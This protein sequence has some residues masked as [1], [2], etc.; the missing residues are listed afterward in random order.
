VVRVVTRQGWLV[1]TVVGY[2]FAGAPLPAFART[3]EN[4]AP[5][6]PN[7]DVPAAM[8]VEVMSETSDAP[9][10]PEATAHGEEQREGETG[11]GNIGGAE[12]GETTLGATP[13]ESGADEEESS[14][15]TSTRPTSLS[16]PTKRSAT[17]QR[18]FGSFEGTYALGGVAVGTT[19]APGGLVLGGELSIVRQTQEFYWVG[20]YVDATYDFSR[21][22]TRVSVGPELGW[23]ALGLDAGY[24]LVLDGETACNGV[25][26]RPLVSIGYVTAYGRVSH[27]FDDRTWLEAGLLLKYPVEF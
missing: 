22:Q 8:E 20:G 13:S 14:A 4:A 2:L 27:L 21:K 12:A 7:P 1:H 17:D 6:L 16:L 9:T 11:E 18:M 5:E 3:Q 24:L 19:F 23:S 10:D 15:A 26:A 25:T